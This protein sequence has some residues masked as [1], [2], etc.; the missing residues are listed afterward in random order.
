MVTFSFDGRYIIK[1]NQYIHKVVK[2]K[3]FA[4]ALFYQ[5]GIDDVIENIAKSCKN[6]TEVRKDPVNSLPHIW[7]EPQENWKIITPP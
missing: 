2:I 4:K 7:E 6:S 3:N 5:S 1:F